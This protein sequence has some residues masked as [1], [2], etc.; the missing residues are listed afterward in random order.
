[1]CFCC[2]LVGRRRPQH[3]HR[4][5]KWSCE[6]VSG[7]EKREKTKPVVPV[8]VGEDPEDEYVGGRIWT[9]ATSILTESENG[10]NA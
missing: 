3:L 1:M 7:L 4:A 6:S 10:E 8:L 5:I 2:W 9:C